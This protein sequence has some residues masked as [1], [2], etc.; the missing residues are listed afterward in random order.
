MKFYLLI[1]LSCFHCFI[2]AQS[3][4]IYF[5]KHW[6]P[7]SESNASYYRTY[8]SGDDTLFTI[9]DYFISGAIQME[10]K[11]P[12][13][14]KI[15][16]YGLTTFYYE[17]G[18]KSS[19]GNYWKNNM[20][21]E[22][23]G[24]HENG[25]KRFRNFYTEEGR[26]EGESTYWHKNG[27][28][29][30]ITIY[31]EGKIIKGGKTYYESGALKLVYD[32]TGSGEKTGEWI[33]YFENQDTS[34]LGNFKKD[35]KHGPWKDFHPGKIPQTSGN[36]S[37]GKKKG[38]WLFYDK[39]GKVRA[40]KKYKKD[41]LKKETYFDESGNEA[42]AENSFSI[43]EFGAGS[44]G[45][46]KEY[47]SAE[48]LIP[49]DSAKE[50]SL[51]ISTKIDEKGEILFIAVNQSLSPFID[52]AFSKA[53]KKM[54]P[55]IAGTYN[56][57]KSAY[58]LDIPIEYRKNNSFSIGDFHALSAERDDI[59]IKHK[60]GGNSLLFTIVE[61]MPVF[62]GGE[63]ELFRFLSENIK[64]P[65]LAKENNIKGVVYVSFIVEVTGC[66]SNVK[67]IKGVHPSIDNE[68]LRVVRAM[69]KWKPGFQ[70]GSPV[71]VS[72]NLPIRFTLK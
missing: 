58:Y 30:S 44:A 17:N 11:S 53:F 38:T 22:W 18:Q 49:G 60:S 20:T 66:I 43:P 72:F 15:T 61:E 36:Y 39:N 70:N 41:I 35:R 32:Y 29:E 62:P 2:Y 19:E 51:L 46:I 63:Q 68:S 54:P 48:I 8:E 57:I 12:D 13:Y 71:R 3:E 31:R 69:P 27:L 52:S 1:A 47:L 59:D 67:I 4:K 37:S 45:G 26:S 64:Y 28:V 6:Q 56:N 65:A 24:W 55:W 25:L 33:K 42:E 50:G 7:C 23:N 40:I 14:K 5:D 16:K 34:T 9:K 21:G 10:S